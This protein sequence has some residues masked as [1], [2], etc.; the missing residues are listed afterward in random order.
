LTSTAGS[1]GWPPG[2]TR[3]SLSARSDRQFHQKPCPLPT[4]ARRAWSGRQANPFRDSRVRQPQGS[5]GTP[6]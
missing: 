6:P 4:T 1:G 3:L 5:L 2:R